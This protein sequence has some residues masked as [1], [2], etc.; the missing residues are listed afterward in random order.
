MGCRVLVNCGCPCEGPPGDGK[1]T[2]IKPRRLYAHLR[3]DI[4]YRCCC[5]KIFTGTT[6]PCSHKDSVQI[7]PR[8]LPDK[9]C[10]FGCNFVGS[11]QHRA[12]HEERKHYL[13]L[14]CGQICGFSKRQ[15]GSHAIDCGGLDKV[16][17]VDAWK[18]LVR[19]DV[20]SGIS[21]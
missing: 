18:Y 8:P 17:K 5:G 7:T 3:E 16:V 20:Y 4:H 9:A 10:M 19:E 1:I 2:K 14:Q 21:Y 11:Q 6:P 12:R 15:V 13:C